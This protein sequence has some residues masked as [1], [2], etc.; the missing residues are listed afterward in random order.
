MAIDKNLAAYAKHLHENGYLLNQELIAAQCI[1]YDW[2]TVTVNDAWD[3]TYELTA[4]GEIALGIQATETDSPASEPQAASE[5]PGD[6]RYHYHLDCGN[7]QTQ[8]RRGELP[9]DS[10]E[11]IATFDTDDMEDVHAENC[12]KAIERETETLR[13]ENA[14]LQAELQAARERVTMLER[15]IDDARY[16]VGDMPNH[17]NGIDT[18]YDEILDL[19]KPYTAS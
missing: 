15:R 17:P 18:L 4:I 9:D 8:V 1:R 12:L 2:I 6:K 14:R 3:I 16:I 5:P 10:S 13:A 11:V 7:H 19:S